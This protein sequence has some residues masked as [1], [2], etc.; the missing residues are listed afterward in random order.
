MVAQHAFGFVS[1]CLSW[2]GSYGFVLGSQ[3]MLCNFQGTSETTKVQF[4]G[5][6]SGLELLWKEFLEQI[7]FQQSV[8]V[9]VWV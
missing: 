3:G 5:H 4:F 8:G 7:I 9:E 1:V 6:W 2:P